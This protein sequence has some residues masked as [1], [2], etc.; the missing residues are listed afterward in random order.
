LTN[1]PFGR[2][3]PRLQTRAISFLRISLP[4]PH[5]CRKRVIAY[6]AN[7]E[8]NELASHESLRLDCVGESYGIFATHLAED[9][10]DSSLR[11]EGLYDPSHVVSAS[12]PPLPD[13]I[14]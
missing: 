8:M 10:T 14:A 2:C 11:I 6:K 5:V 4:Y 3:H 13:Y 1:R 7:T 12:L 9:N